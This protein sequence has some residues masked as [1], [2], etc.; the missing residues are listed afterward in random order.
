MAEKILVID[1]K[2]EMT[3]LLKRALTEE[4]YEVET[5]HDGQEGLRQTHV[6][7]PDLIVLDIMMPGMGGLDMLRRLRQFSD[8]PV[9]ILT[10]V[11]TEDDKVY[12]LNIGADDYVT[13]PF[14]IRELKARIQATLRRVAHPS[15]SESRILRFDG[16]RL[17]IEPQSH[18]VI[19]R[20]EEVSLTPTEYK[21]LLYLAYNAGRVLSYEQIL[22]NVWGPGYENGLT[23]VK[24]YV[25]YLRRKIE[26]DPTNPRYILTQRG[27]G[28]SLTKL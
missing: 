10:A 7:R 8:V 21:L 20:G 18:K 9:I 14:A 3:W 22:D 4:G 11:N 27:V 28:Y 25:W 17:T 26:E 16:D 12:G 5:A 19:V 1:D 15:S 24:L 2:P 13:K 23:N 6:F